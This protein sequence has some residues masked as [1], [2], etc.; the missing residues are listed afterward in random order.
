MVEGDKHQTYIIKH[1]F[2]CERHKEPVFT[3][4]YFFIQIIRKLKYEMYF[5]RK[6]KNTKKH[7]F[8]L[9]VLMLHSFA[10]LLQLYGLHN[11]KIYLNKYNLYST[12]TDFDIAFRA[13]AGQ[14][15][16]N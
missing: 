3:R 9:E 8:S 1:I 13:H 11:R 10:T 5:F 7:S 6:V 2:K 14:Y 16:D 15:E 4:K 12:R